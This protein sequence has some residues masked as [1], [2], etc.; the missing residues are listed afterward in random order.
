RGMVRDPWSAP[1]DTD[2]T[3]SLRN[4]PR[5]EARF[6]ALRMVAQLS[7]ARGGREGIF[8]ARHDERGMMPARSPGIVGRLHPIFCHAMR[9]AMHPGLEVRID[10][11]TKIESEMG[12]EMERVEIAFRE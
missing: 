5:G 1:C 8:S 2:P 9:S 3:S 10:M 7:G 4:P 12:R 6:I 11:K